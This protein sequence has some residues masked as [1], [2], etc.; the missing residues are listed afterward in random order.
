MS[1]P[2]KRPRDPAGPVAGGSGLAWACVLALALLGAPAPGAAQNVDI[3]VIRIASSPSP[4]GS[5]ARAAGYGGAFIAIAD[6]ATAASWNPGGLAQ[7]EAPEV[8]AV[9]ELDARIEDF[10]RS[11]DVSGDLL[12]STTTAALNY[13][14]AVVPFHLFRLNMT[15]SL[16][17]QRVMDFDRD[18]NF[19]LVL[20]QPPVL[21][22][23]EQVGFEQRGALDTIS[24]AFCV[25]LTPRLSFGLAV[26]VWLDDLFSGR[27]WEARTRA[28]GTGT[29]DPGGASVPFRVSFRRDERFSGI[30]GVNVA[31]GMLWNAWRGLTVGAVL[32][33]PFQ[34]RADRAYAW[35][36]IV[37]D[38]VHPE[39]PDPGLP[40]SVVVPPTTEEVE[41]RFPW[42]FGVG[43]AYRF[44]DF[45]VASLDVTR[46]EWD[47]F[48]IVQTDPWLGV[49]V[50]TS[51][52]TGTD[53]GTSG[54][55]G[56]QTVRTGAEYVLARDRF[57][58][59]LRAGFA[60]DPVPARGG[61]E[62]VFVFS[63]GTG[64]S[65]PRLSFDMAYTLSFG[66]G[67]E[68]DL[69]SGVDETVLDLTVHRFLFSLIC[70][71]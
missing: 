29:E 44:S 43:L 31:A 68:G 54:V 30:T 28:R 27:A 48:V 18:L 52:F 26:N 9:G 17:F 8:S 24:P 40:P 42:A 58:V 71:I 22:L 7:I 62:N 16:N 1:L 65:L 46:V 49:K 32:K 14:S 12:N 60:Y 57:A 55:H 61:S 64:L 70:Y 66:R 53:A 4:V 35:S 67:L 39:S 20:D 19:G 3:P 5:G 56:L 37:E 15:A 51:P 38:A 13:L 47:D 50:E 25:Q 45:C 36:V 11:R 6:D 33:T 10:S 41:I 59:P 23:Q 34:V 69:Y 2:V 21:E 63:F